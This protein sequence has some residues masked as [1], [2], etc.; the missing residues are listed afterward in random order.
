VPLLVDKI[1]VDLDFHVFDV[2]NLDLL[3]GSHIKK[4]FDAS[5]GS[6]DKKLREAVSA[7]IPLYTENSKVTPL[8]KQNPF[9]EMK[10]VEFCTS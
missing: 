8:P 7:T 9:E 10:L 4:L 3:L 1:K 6:L 5:R 2:L